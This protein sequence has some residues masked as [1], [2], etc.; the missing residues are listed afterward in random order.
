MEEAGIRV[1]D[2]WILERPLVVDGGESAFYSGM[3]L[4]PAPDAF[5]C[6]GDYAALGVLQAAK[7]KGMRVPEDLGVSGFA[8]EPFTAYLEPSL[9]TVDQKGIQ[10]GKRLADM[11]LQCEKNA[12]PSQSCERQILEP[13]LIIRNSSLLNN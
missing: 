4:A 6:S 1:P 11:F 8:N 12:L 7:S 9:T 10:M 13:E 5:F 2:A 3:E